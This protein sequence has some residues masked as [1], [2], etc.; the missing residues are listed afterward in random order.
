MVLALQREEYDHGEKQ[1][2]QGN[3]RNA[4]QQHGLVPFLAAGAFAEGSGE[5]SG[6]QRDP[7]EYHDGDGDSSKGARTSAKRSSRAALAAVSP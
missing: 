3:R 4:W 2:I 6:D 1:P 7:Q 5:E